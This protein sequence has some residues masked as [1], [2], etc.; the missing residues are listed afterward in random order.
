M[1]R[2]TLH[3]KFIS[4]LAATSIALTGFTAAPASADDDVAKLLGALVGIAALG[5]VIKEIKDKDRHQNVHRPQVVHKP[6]PKPQQVHKPK[7]KQHKTHQTRPLPSRFL[8]PSRCLRTVPVHNHNRVAA[9]G[10]RCL[11]RHYDFSHSLPQR[12][13]RADH[14]RNG[15]IYSYG[16]RC[17]KRAGYKI[18]R[19]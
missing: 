4:G 14:G 1:S 16:A 17:L 19:Q 12:C 6:K 15:I 13:A 5:V 11:S 9:F 7:H 8:L 18:A 3:L 2:K 10:E